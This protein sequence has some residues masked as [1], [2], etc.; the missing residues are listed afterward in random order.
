MTTKPQKASCTIGRLAESQIRLVSDYRGPVTM[1]NHNGKES[2]DLA[3]RAWNSVTVFNR[4]FLLRGQSDS[5]FNEQIPSD[6]LQQT[7]PS[8][9]EEA[10]VANLVKSLG[11]NVIQKASDELLG[12]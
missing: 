6:L 9:S 8:V 12:T 11:Q 2:P 1:M 5:F 10:I 4:I 3:D 7:F